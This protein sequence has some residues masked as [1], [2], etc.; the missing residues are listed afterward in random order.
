MTLKRIETTQKHQK[1]KQ[2]KSRDKK[3]V[4]IDLESSLLAMQTVSFYLLFG[5]LFI[6]RRFMYCPALYL[7]SDIIH[8]HILPHAY[9]S[10]KTRTTT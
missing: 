5:V 10:T 1:K 4:F 8:L 3:S 6:V 2:Y 9:N 7:L